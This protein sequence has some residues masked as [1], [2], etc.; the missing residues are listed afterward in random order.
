[1]AALSSSSAAYHARF[2]R[3]LVAKDMHHRARQQERRHREE[4]MSS[5]GSSQQGSDP[6]SPGYMAPSPANGNL[7]TPP[8]GTPIMPG[9]GYPATSPGTSGGNNY[10]HHPH[11]PPHGPPSSSSGYHYNVPAP[12][13]GGPHFPLPAD[14]QPGQRMEGGQRMEAQ[15]HPPQQPQQGRGGD[16]VYQQQPQSEMDAQYWNN[17]FVQ[18][19]FNGSQDPGYHDGSLQQFGDPMSA[20]EGSSMGGMI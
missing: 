17:M 3:S 10:H 13:H 11:H 6:R 5:S 1:M 2:L 14:G 20:M 18:L 9:N 7:V 16:Y 15:F 8:N 19:G 12:R 4:G